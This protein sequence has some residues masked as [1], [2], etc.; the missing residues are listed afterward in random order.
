[1]GHSD[2]SRIV[3]LSFLASGPCLALFFVGMGVICSVGLVDP[4]QTYK[5]FIHT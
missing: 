2:Y 3:R 4:D 5:T 1:M